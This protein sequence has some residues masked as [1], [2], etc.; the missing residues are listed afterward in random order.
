MSIGWLQPAAVCLLSPP[1]R[2]SVTPHRRTVTS[3]WTSSMSPSGTVK[4]L[5]VEGP[6]L[7]PVGGRRPRSGQPWARSGS[8]LA[9]AVP[10]HSRTDR[11]LGNCRRWS[12]SYGTHAEDRQLGRVLEG[13]TLVAHR[14]RR[15][16]GG[17]TQHDRPRLVRDLGMPS[18]HPGE[19]VRIDTLRLG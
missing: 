19:P 12:H 16:N 11:V 10:E 13:K 4:Q 6:V 8:L 14:K 18:K 3:S 1:R 17:L 7:N 15:A 2:S 5:S 9:Q